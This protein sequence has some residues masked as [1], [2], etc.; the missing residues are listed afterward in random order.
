[1]PLV[2]RIGRIFHKEDPEFTA[3]PQEVQDLIRIGQGKIIWNGITRKLSRKERKIESQLHAIEL[4]GDT[5]NE[6]ALSQLSQWYTPQSQTIRHTECNMNGSDVISDTWS[7]KHYEYPK[8]PER[9][10]QVFNFEVD[11]TFSGWGLEHSVPDEE[12][13]NRLEEQ[14]ST[15]PHLIMRAAIAKLQD[16]VSKPTGK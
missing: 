13:E 12:I 3:A 5:G 11:I 16:S 6:L 8:M 2:E 7:V 4:L 9:L 10:K 1:M 14:Y 15:R